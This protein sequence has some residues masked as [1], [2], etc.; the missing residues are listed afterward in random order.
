MHHFRKYYS[1]DIE[2]IDLMAGS[3]I[4]FERI[5]WWQVGVFGFF[6]RSYPCIFFSI[7][8]TIRAGLRIQLASKSLDLAYVAT[9]P[10]TRA[11]IS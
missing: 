11:Y 3:E 6:P 9:V 4:N 10:N 2:P 1:K 8:W 5:G 7:L